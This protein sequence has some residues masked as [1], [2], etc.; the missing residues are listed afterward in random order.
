M[1]DEEFD[2]CIEEILHDKKDGLHKIYSAY[3]TYIYVIIYD[4][5]KNKEDAEDVTTE[6]FIKIW[7]IAGKYQTGRGHRAW[8]GKIAHNMAIDYIRGMKRHDSYDEIKEEKESSE[9]GFEAGMIEKMS[10]KQAIST[11]EDTEQKIVNMKILGQLTFQEIADILKKPI[12]TVS[13]K[14][15]KAIEKLR[16]CHL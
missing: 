15:R 12:G 3:S 9:E 4:I 1:T 11:L 6:F 5:I 8:L 13:W 2:A 16:R 10:I 7:K 14:Y